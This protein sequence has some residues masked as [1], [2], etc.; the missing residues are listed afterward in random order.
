MFPRQPQCTGSP[1]HHPYR[2]CYLWMTC[3]S[4]ISDWVGF[5]WIGFL[6][7]FGFPFLLLFF[8]V[9]RYVNAS[10][11]YQNSSGLT[12]C[13]D[14][15]CWSIYKSLYSVNEMGMQT[16]GTTAPKPPV[17]V[18][19]PTI[20]RMVK[21][22]SATLPRMSSI[23]IVGP[24][25]APEVVTKVQYKSM[26]LFVILL[27]L[28]LIGLNA[29]LYVKLWELESMEAHKMQ[30][31]DFTKMRY[32]ECDYSCMRL[33]IIILVFFIF[34]SYRFCFLFI[35]FQTPTLHPIDLHVHHPLHL[36]LRCNS[37]IILTLCGTLTTTTHHHN[38]VPL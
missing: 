25:S 31:P 6:L 37:L 12:I 30:Y 10:L 32:V 22:K 28:L 15:V 14:S 5:S 19:D 24:A 11:L 23:P 2:W 38:L 29:F 4:F 21:T 36:L 3:F 8:S 16:T 27:L 35:C 26:S 13:L 20:S 9:S 33:L 17:E 34:F 18:F 7:I 1:P